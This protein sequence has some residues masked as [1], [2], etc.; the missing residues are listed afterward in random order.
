M[1]QVARLGFILVGLHTAFSGIRGLASFIPLSLREESEVLWFLVGVQ[2]FFVVL[3]AVVL[4]VFNHTLS[5]FLFEEEPTQI[6][7]YDLVA[8]G[9][10]VLG[11]YLVIIGL[12]GALSFLVFAAASDGSPNMFGPNWGTVGWGVLQGLFGGLLFRYPNTI[13]RRLG[14]HAA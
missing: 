6:A 1:R 8:A 12:S 7:S 11:A 5:V 2:L 9:L 10:A 14:T 4:V 3:P 13:L